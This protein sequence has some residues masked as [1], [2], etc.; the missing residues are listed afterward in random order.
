MNLENTLNAIL[1][2]RLVEVNDK[3]KLRFLHD[4]LEAAEG[5]ARVSHGY[6]EEFW[7]KQ[8]EVWKEM[9]IAE[10]TRQAHGSSGGGH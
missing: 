6:L 9:L 5:M 8:A 2:D 7:N 10:T 1:E 4:S 3:S